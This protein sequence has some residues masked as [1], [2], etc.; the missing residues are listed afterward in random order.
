MKKFATNLIEETKRNICSHIMEML[1][2]LK[3][4]KPITTFVSNECNIELP[5]KYIIDNIKKIII[6]NDNILYFVKNNGD[7]VK[8]EELNLYN[9]KNLSDNLDCLY[10]D[11]VYSADKF[12]L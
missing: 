6:E 5:S 2:K 10:E 9:F 1:C 7:L 3:E 4:F 11:I 8:L 12:V